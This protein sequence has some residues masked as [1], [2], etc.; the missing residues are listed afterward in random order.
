MKPLAFCL[1]L[2][3]IDIIKYDK[4]FSRLIVAILHAVKNDILEVLWRDQAEV[5]GSFSPVLM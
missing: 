2:T 5:S 1:K 3:D 4:W